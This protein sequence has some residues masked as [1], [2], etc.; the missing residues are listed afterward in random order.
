MDEFEIV[1]RE[2]T[3]IVTANDEYEAVGEVEQMLG[4]I[5]M[6]WTQVEVL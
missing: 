6:D 3:F 4:H 2:V 1:V 5:A